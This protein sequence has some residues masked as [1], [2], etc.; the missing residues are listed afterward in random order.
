MVKAGGND[1]I[2]RRLNAFYKLPENS[3][4][5]LLLGASTVRNGFSPLEL[6]AGQGI[7]AYILS[8]AFQNPMVNYYY[9]VEALK[10]QHPQVIVLDT[11]WLVRPFDI[12]EGESFIRLAVDPMK[13]S[14]NKLLFV[15]AIVQKS[16]RQSLSSYLFPLLRYHSRWKELSLED[17]A[18]WKQYAENP[19]RGQNLVS[20]S[21]PLTLSEK[22]FTPTDNVLPIDDTAK[23]Y[24]QM[25]F[26]LCNQNEID[27]I[28]VT[29]PRY[30]WNRAK[31]NAVQLF[32]DQH[33]LVYFDYSSPELMKQ[34]GFDPL[35]DFLDRE[36][37]NSNAAKKITAHLSAFL[38][39][40]YWLRDKRKDPAFSVW[41]EDYITYKKEL[42]VE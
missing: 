17:L 18:I 35:T 22:A 30:S 42:G 23:M 41:N 19:F 15:Q 9:L 37:V 3:L 24:Y 14:L 12:D 36:H 10:Y 40:N 21:T 13:F 38:E 34:I 39:R 1:D 6:W 11:S 27:V 7:T 2:R 29:A 32:A 8:N 16:S 26:N 28:L 31:H 4:D 33:Q 20:E 25:I 5:V